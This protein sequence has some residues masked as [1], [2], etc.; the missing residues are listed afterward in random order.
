MSFL[1]NKYQ[2]IAISSP[3]QFPSILQN[4]LQESNS[5]KQIAFDNE[6]EEEGKELTWI[7]S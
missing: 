6:D 3:I 5:F 7:K 2:D 4:L 1:K